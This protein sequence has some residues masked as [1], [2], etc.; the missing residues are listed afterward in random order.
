MSTGVVASLDR[1]CGLLD[2]DL[3]HLTV[4]VNFDIRCAN[5]LGM[6]EGPHHF[7]MAADVTLSWLLPW[8]PIT[9]LVMDSVKSVHV[10]VENRLAS[11]P[12]H[13]LHALGANVYRVHKTFLL[14]APVSLVAVVVERFF[15]DRDRM[16]LS[17]ET[18]GCAHT[19][20]TVPNNTDIELLTWLR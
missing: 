9:T 8:H 4:L 5:F 6:L 16:T 20:R 11:Q 10:D 13:G 19:G 2:I 1:D 12:V 18:N 14:G 3:C 7:K 17:A 15:I